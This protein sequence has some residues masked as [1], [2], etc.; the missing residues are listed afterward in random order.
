MSD[1]Q[2]ALLTGGA[3]ALLALLQASS[4]NA[5]VL[6]GG[7]GG[8][9]WTGTDPG[10]APATSVG[11]IQL[12]GF[13][14]GTLVLSS[15]NLSTPFLRFYQQAVGLS[16]SASFALT[17]FGTKLPTAADQWTYTVSPS[18]GTGWVSWYVP[19]MSSAYL[20]YKITALSG[21][22]YFWVFAAPEPTGLTISGYDSLPATAGNGGGRGRGGGTGTPEPAASGLALLALGAAGI[23]RHKRR[24]K[25][26]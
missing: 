3:G 14:S 1:A 8:G 6:L 26:A 2:R 17:A 12:T 24:K 22:S 11:K 15:V 7:G 19:L 21:T 4:A 23:L 18:I 20:G 13:G 16:A 10:A 5:D 9:T 25:P